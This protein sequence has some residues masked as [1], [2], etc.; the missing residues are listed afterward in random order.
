MTKYFVFKNETNGEQKNVVGS[1][2]EIA[3]DIAIAIGEEAFP[4]DYYI[5]FP[6]ENDLALPDSMSE[7]LQFTVEI[8]DEREKIWIEEA[9]VLLKNLKNLDDQ[10]GEASSILYSATLKVEK[11][12]SNCAHFQDLDYLGTKGVDAI[13][14]NI[15]DSGVSEFIDYVYSL[16]E[17]EAFQNQNA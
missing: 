6:Q 1:R 3:C 8:D 16:F 10:I 12:V 17:V 5:A 4:R 9:S 14:E 7:Y 2:E 15:D 11:T 13:F